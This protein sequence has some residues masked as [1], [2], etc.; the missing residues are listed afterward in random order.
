MYQLFEINCSIKTRNL[1]RKIKIIK[2]SS[3]YQLLNSKYLLIKVLNYVEQLKFSTIVNVKPNPQNAQQLMIN[4]AISEIN[5]DFNYCILTQQ[6][7]QIQNYGYIDFKGEKIYQLNSHLSEYFAIVNLSSNSF[8]HDAILTIDQLLSHCII[9]LKNG[10]SVLDLGAEST[11]PQALAIS[12][13][14]ELAILNKFLPEILNLKKDYN[15]KISIDSYHPETIIQ[16]LNYEIDF[17]NDVSGNLPIVVLKNIQATAKEYIFMHSLVIPADK[18]VQMKQDIDPLITISRWAEDKINQL[19]GLGF[20]SESLSFD[21][22]IGFAK[23]RWQNR[24][25]LQNINKFNYLNSKILVGHSRKSFINSQLNLTAGEKD[26]ETAM[27][28]HYL[29]NQWIDYIRIHNLELNQ[30]INIIGSEYL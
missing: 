21:P 29:T 28:S 30:R 8:S 17:I 23:S 26:P 15:F 4:L 16:L 22:G 2:H 27:I 6:I 5:R 19:L 24:Y 18:K 20:K 14:E 3:V 12:S 7:L 13:T 11:N 25:I 1:M 9:Q 10:A